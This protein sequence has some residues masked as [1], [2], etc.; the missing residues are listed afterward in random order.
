MPGEEF[1]PARA[2]N[3]DPV[4]DFRSYQTRQQGP[5]PADERLASLEFV[6]HDHLCGLRDVVC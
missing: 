4:D 2:T 3:D 5:S 1:R 6:L